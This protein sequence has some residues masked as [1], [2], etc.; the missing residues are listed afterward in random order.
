MQRRHRRP[1]LVRVLFGI[2]MALAMPHSARVA[3][4]MSNMAVV[5][6]V[7]LGRG[8]MAVV[9]AVPLGRGAMA[10]AVVVPVLRVRVSRVPLMRV[11]MRM[12]MRVVI[13]LMT[14]TMTMTMQMSIQVL[15]MP[16]RVE[17]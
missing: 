5:M 17:V 1:F 10:V 8:A 11:P 13:I 14:M 6:T 15:Q 3:M 12:A 2:A 9:V 7:P 4:S 16:R